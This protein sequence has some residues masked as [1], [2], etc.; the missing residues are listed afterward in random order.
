[1]GRNKNV[2][3]R[4]MNLWF[5]HSACCPML[6]NIYMKFMKIQSHKANRTVSAVVQAWDLVILKVAPPA[7]VF[8]NWETKF[9]F[10]DNFDRGYITADKLIALGQ[11]LNVVHGVKNSQMC[12]Q[13]KTSP[14]WGPLPISMVLWYERSLKS[15]MLSLARTSKYANNTNMLNVKK[16]EEDSSDWKGLP[17]WIVIVVSNK[18]IY[19]IWKTK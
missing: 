16:S 4:V 9:K 5:W 13:T 15:K 8:R 14:R 6:V 7:F 11:L 10:F 17:N 19:A 18:N 1:M 2:Y 3:P 12:I